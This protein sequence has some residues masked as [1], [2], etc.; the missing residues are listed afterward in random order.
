MMAQAVDESPRRTS[1]SDHMVVR[2]ARTTASESESTSV[3]TTSEVP[4]SAAVAQ[5][6]GGLGWNPLASTTKFSMLDIP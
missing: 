2:R 3:R 4:G 1:D 6:T 5:S